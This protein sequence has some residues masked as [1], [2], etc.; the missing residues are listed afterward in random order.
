VHLR[1]GLSQSCASIRYAAISATKTI[2]VAGKSLKRGTSRFYLTSPRST[3]LTSSPFST[4]NCA[5][6]ERC[7]NA[8]SKLL[9]GITA[10]ALSD[11]WHPGRLVGDLST[12]AN[13]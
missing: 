4:L 9:C 10:A 6:T 2:E 3:I 12:E 5:Q 11:H 7:S 1:R 8:S 13:S